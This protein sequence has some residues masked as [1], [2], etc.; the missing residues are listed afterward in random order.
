MEPPKKPDNQRT[1]S[2]KIKAGG[3]TIPEHKVDC[4][5]VEIKNNVALAQ[6]Q[7]RDQ[8]DIIEAPHMY[9]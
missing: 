1:L 5:A 2:K 7:T 9:T 3:I 4:R 6:K 8:R